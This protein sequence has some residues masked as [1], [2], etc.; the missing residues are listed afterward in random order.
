MRVGALMMGCSRSTLQGVPEEACSGPLTWYVVV[1]TWWDA[2]AVDA[3]VMA[4]GASAGDSGWH[5]YVASSADVV[6]AV[7][8]LVDHYVAC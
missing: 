3:D 5:L 7:G 4:A 8:N 1:A 2:G 6:D